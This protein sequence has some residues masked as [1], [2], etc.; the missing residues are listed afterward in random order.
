MPAL[1]G[2][3]RKLGIGLGDVQVGARLHELLIEIGRVDFGEHVAGLHLAADIVLPA[4][5]IPRDARV[6]RRA[7]VGFEA[8]GQVQAR[9]IADAA[10]VTM[11]TIGTA[12]SSVNSCRREF[13]A[14]RDTRP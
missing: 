8:S 7:D 12:C 11:A 13:C 10:G 1:G 9:L 6:D 2:D 5:Q 14:A 4:L 3:L